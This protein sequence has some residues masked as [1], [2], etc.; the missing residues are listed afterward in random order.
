MHKVTSPA[1]MNAAFAQ[2]FNSREITRLLSLYELDAALQ[3]DDS[4]GVLRGHTKIRMALEGLLLVPGRMTSQNSFCIEYGDIALLR[5]DWVIE[6]AAGA[7][8]AEGCSAE[9]VRR[10]SDGSWLYVIDH[11][12]GASLPRRTHL[13]S[14][15]VR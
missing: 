3:V 12:L 2:A 13:G 14:A 11:A 8:V 4:A 15:V 1:D 10:Q 7:A 9:V 6:D 5:A